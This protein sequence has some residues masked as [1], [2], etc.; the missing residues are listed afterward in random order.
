MH[1]ELRSLQEHKLKS[2]YSTTVNPRYTSLILARPSTS[3]K[4][5]QSPTM[6]SISASLGEYSLHVVGW[7]IIM[8]YG[9]NNP[10]RIT[11]SPDPIH[12]HLYQPIHETK[13]IERPKSLIATLRLS[14]QELLQLRNP[15]GLRGEFLCDRETCI[16]S[17]FAL[18]SDQTRLDLI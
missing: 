17:D 18:R 14:S 16:F 4:L 8:R 10:M 15:K 6:V 2:R 3:Y 9:C 7:I 1:C 5:S 11:Y 13:P 12:C